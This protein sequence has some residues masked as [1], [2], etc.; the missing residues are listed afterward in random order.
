[1]ICIKGI[2]EESIFIKF[3]QKQFKL[4]IQDGFKNADDGKVLLC[5][6]YVED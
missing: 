2:R 1:M 3:I 6:K 5:R 4:N